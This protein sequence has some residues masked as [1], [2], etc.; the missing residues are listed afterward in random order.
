MDVS[1][2]R[3]HLNHNW[4]NLV[5]LKGLTKIDILKGGFTSSEKQ[6]LCVYYN[7]IH[8][9]DD[10]FDYKIIS[11]RNKSRDT[12]FML[13]AFVGNVVMMEY[14]DNKKISIN[15]ANNYGDDA[16]LMA[17]YSGNLNVLKYLES[18]M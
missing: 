3:T 17:T 9:L 18:K 11:K 12:I 8:T 13:D 2:Y 15:D 7:Y 10:I 5:N 16:Y 4:N 1:G 6:W 14:L